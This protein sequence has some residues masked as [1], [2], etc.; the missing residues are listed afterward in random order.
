[1]PYNPDRK[2]NAIAKEL[3]AAYAEWREARDKKRGHLGA[4]IVG[5]KCVRHIWYA[6]RWAWIEKH[7]GRMLRLFDRGHDEEN[8]IKK[9]LEIAGH[10]IVDKQA[11]GKQFQF[12]DHNGHF[13]GSCDGFVS[14]EGR[15]PLPQDMGWGLLEDKTHNTKSFA[16]LLTKGIVQSKLSHYVQ[17][18]T[19]MKYFKVHWALYFPVNKDNDD[20]EPQ[21]VLYKPEVGN[22]HSDLAKQ[23]IE[24]PKPPARISNDSSWWVCRMCAFHDICHHNKEPKK[25]C[26]MCEHSQPV[27]YGKWRCNLYG[28]DIPTLEHQMA[29]CDNWSQ[30]KP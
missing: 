6:Y 3:D 26:R 2:Q 23:I 19:Y 1:V 17:M 11:N 30:I 10:T 24:C 14:P 9:W 4:S 16:T 7:K 28:A 22:Y 12:T 25:T 29:G 21:V 20:I 18:H 13:S 8:R 5:H 15:L 27:K